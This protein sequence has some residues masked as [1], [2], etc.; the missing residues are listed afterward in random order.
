MCEAL[1]LFIAAL[2]ASTVAHCVLRTVNGQSVSP[3]VL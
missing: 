1:P 3:L 2:T